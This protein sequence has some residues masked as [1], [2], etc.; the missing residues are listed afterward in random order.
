MRSEGGAEAVP[1]HPWYTRPV[2]FVGDLARAIQLGL[3]RD[4]GRR[5]DGNELLFPF[6]T[7]REAVGSD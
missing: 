3:R 5:P 7:G 6:E 4:R 2:L 1:V